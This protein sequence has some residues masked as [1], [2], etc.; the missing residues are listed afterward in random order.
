MAHPADLLALLQACKD[1]PTD[2]QPRLVLAD[3]LEER[4]EQDRAEV[5][6]LQLRSHP[7]AE[8]RPEA[9]EELGGSLRLLRRHAGEWVGAALDHT[10]WCRFPGRGGPLVWSRRGLLHVQTGA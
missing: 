5:V 8:W 4:G 9:A 10:G 3:W 1:E 2:D 6:R 7:A